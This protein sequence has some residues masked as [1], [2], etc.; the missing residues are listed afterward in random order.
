M[1]IKKVA[2]RENVKVN[3]RV[4]LREWCS[5][6]RNLEES[7]SEIQIAGEREKTIKAAI[8]TK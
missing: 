5:T 3:K 2:K 4:I 8:N 1:K 7:F 6:K